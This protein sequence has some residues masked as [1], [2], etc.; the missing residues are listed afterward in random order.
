[1]NIKLLQQYNY[2]DVTCGGQIPMGTGMQ[3]LQVYLCH[4]CI[5]IPLLSKPDED[6]GGGEGG[7]QRDAEEM[8]RLNH[9]KTQKCVR[10]LHRVTDCSWF[11]IV[12][13]QKSRIPYNSFT[14]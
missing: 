14:F 12:P 5:R 6:G 3:T 13:M 4:R 10:R 2:A 1:M 8:I 9:T 7:T 11:S